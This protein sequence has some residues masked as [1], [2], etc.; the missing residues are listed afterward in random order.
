MGK[1]SFLMYHLCI[2]SK[3]IELRWTPSGHVM[4]FSFVSTG[5]CCCR[6]QVLANDSIAN[7]APTRVK[8]MTSATRNTASTTMINAEQI[9]RNTSMRS[10]YRNYNP[11]RKK[12]VKSFTMKM[13]TLT[14]WKRLTASGFCSC[15]LSSSFLLL[16]HWR[17]LNKLI[18]QQI[19]INRSELC[20]L[21]NHTSLLTVVHY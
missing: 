19:S 20:Y 15:S 1:L 12:F 10:A 2:W 9:I 7:S 6:R 16:N 14:I 18:K 17:R 13:N 21:F 4:F 11:M 3:L 5:T 8:R